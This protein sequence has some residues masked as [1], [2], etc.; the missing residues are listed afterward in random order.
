MHVAA[1][2]EAQTDLGTHV[3]W[4]RGSTAIFDICMVILDAGSYL[5]MTPEKALEKADKEKKDK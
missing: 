3:F 5:P 2:E 1:P 4:K